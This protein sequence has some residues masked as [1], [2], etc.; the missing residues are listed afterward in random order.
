M[1][2]NGAFLKFEKGNS[3]LLASLKEFAAHYDGNVWGR[4]G[5]KLLTRVYH[6]LMNKNG[7][8]DVNV[9]DYTFSDMIEKCFKDTEGIIL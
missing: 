7:H 9:V 2:L 5:P 8:A 4:N 1:N 3:F 6:E